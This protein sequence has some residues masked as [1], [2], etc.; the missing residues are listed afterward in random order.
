[1][2]RLFFWLGTSGGYGV[3]LLLTLT[4]VA[5]VAFFARDR[6]G[7]NAWRRLIAPA[8]AAVLLGGIVVLATMHYAT[9]LG[10]PPGTPIAWMLPASYLAVAVIGE[11]WAVVLKSRR[12]HVY[13]AIGLGPHSVTTQLTRSAE[14]T[15]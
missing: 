8:I 10:V 7:E 5:I 2:V 4:A 9:L 14:G 3:L 11:V 1:M 13:D 12:P 6:R 15:R